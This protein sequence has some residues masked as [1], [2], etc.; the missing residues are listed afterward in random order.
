MRK[1]I[2][3]S[4]TLIAAVA[5]VLVLPVLAIEPGDLSSSHQNINENCLSCHTLATG[6]SSDKCL[7]CHNLAEITVSSSFHQYLAES[8]CMTCHALHADKRS[9]VS[10]SEFSHESLIYSFLQNM[11]IMP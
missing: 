11:C 5:F 6:V 2:I 9:Q 8:D 1:A 4:I 10:E 3:L 7:D